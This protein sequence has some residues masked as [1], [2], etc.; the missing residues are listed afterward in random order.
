MK[1]QKQLAQNQQNTNNNGKNLQ[2]QSD[3]MREQLIKNGLIPPV[4]QKQRDTFASQFGNPY[5]S[6]SL[7]TFSN[8]VH[9]VDVPFAQMVARQDSRYNPLQSFMLC[10]QLNNDLA[11]HGYIFG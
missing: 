10:Q 8:L 6:T 4:D 9:N 2:T 7:G 1:Q 3:E 11:A 5:Q